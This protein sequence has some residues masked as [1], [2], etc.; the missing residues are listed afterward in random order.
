M[1]AGDGVFSQNIRI[2]HNKVGIHDE[3]TFEGSRQIS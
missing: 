2:F 1:M 3:T